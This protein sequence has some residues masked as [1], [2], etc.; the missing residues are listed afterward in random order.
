MAIILGKEGFSPS[1]PKNQNRGDTTPLKSLYSKNGKKSFGF[2]HRD[3]YPDKVLIPIK[4]RQE[5]T[6]LTV[7]QL[8][9]FLSKKLYPKIPKK[10][11]RKKSP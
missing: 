11:I 5:F 3:D 7:T 6:G 9:R 4:L 10:D 1:I 8:S 2:K